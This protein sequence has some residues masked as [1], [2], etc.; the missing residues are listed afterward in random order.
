[1]NEK[2][3]EIQNTKEKELIYDDILGYYTLEDIKKIEKILD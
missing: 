3:K 1:M 2:V